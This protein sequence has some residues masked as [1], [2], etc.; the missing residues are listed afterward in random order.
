MSATSPSTTS[1]DRLASGYSGFFA[2]PGGS[3]ILFAA[4]GHFTFTHNESGNDRI[5]TG[6]GNDIL[7]TGLGD[8]ALNSGGG[9]DQIN[10][11]AGLDRWSVS[12]ANA[13]Q[14]IVINLN[15]ASTFLGTGS[16]VNIEGFGGGAGIVT[17]SGNDQIT[18]HNT[19]EV[20]DRIETSA[21]NDTVILAGG[22]GLDLGIGGSGSDRLVV[23]YNNNDGVNGGVSLGSLATGYDAGFIIPG[24]N[25]INCNDIEHF[26]FTN[27]GD[28]V[29]LI[30]AGDGNDILNGGPND[31]FLNGSGGIDRID[32][33]TGI[34]AVGL[35][36]GSA[37]QAITIDLN[38]ASTFLGTGLL[39][40]AEGFGFTLTTGSG[41]DKITGHAT[42]GLEDRI[43]TGGGNDIVTLTAGGNDNVD[44]GTGA[45]RLD[46]TFKLNGNVSMN[47]QGNAGLFD[48]PGQNDILFSNVEHLT[49]T[50]TGDGLDAITTGDGNDVITSGANNDNI[51]TAGGIDLIN[52]GAGD[53]QVKAGDGNDTIVGGSGA[54]NDFYKA[55]CRDRHDH[56][57][58]R[59]QRHNRQL[60]SLAAQ[61]EA[62][63]AATRLGASRTSSAA[64]PVTR[65]SATTSSIRSP[66]VPAT[67][68]STAA[69]ATIR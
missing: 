26:T 60:S 45:D 1:A 15:T 11:G 10:G 23:T 64:L 4:F 65:S 17:G 13:T 31:D 16:V 66:A 49:Y 25:N 52:T 46:V 50:N 57:C 12:L 34:D 28:G 69:W 37:T 59:H 55:I 42:A 21:G 19:A 35:N 63:S 54:S 3:N 22:K 43:N 5:N 27:T 44:A 29:D 61:S 18:G 51:N 32:G 40:N 24:D 67:T 6:D 30:T 2:G 9:I 8:D 48:G 36:L 39:K 47:A 20:E 41:A 33:G 56:L 68:I 7:N 58:Q 14:A 38:G 53:D 62:R